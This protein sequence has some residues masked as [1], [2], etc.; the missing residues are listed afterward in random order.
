MDYN[1]KIDRG[2]SE[3]KSEFPPSFFASNVELL[4]KLLGKAAPKIESQQLVLN[5]SI[6]K[7]ENKFLIC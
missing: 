2:R 1:R 5:Q 6:N 3:N 4:Q 7:V